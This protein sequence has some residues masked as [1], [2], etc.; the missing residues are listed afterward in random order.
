M[1]LVHFQTTVLRLP[2]VDR[3]L[4]DA[5]FP[6]HILGLAPSLYL[7]QRSNDLRLR[8]L[9]LAQFALLP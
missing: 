7:L 8:L 6:G 3:V 9:A 2:G 4:R 5:V 1:R